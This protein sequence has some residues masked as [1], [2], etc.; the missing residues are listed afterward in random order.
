MTNT[1]FN[2]Y[3]WNKE[4]LINYVKDNLGDDAKVIYYQNNIVGINTIT[5][6]SIRK[7]TIGII[8]K[9]C[10]GTIPEIWDYYLSQD[11]CVSY[12]VFFNFNVNK[13]S[14]KSIIAL[15]CTKANECI[16]ID[17]CD[18]YHKFCTERISAKDNNF[19]S[20]KEISNKLGILSVDFSKAI[21][22]IQKSIFVNPNSIKDYGYCKALEEK[23]F[24]TY[25]NYI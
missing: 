4:S 21:Q 14:S 7:L 6:E 5:F 10:Y 25:K 8:K 11:D 17:G 13:N 23:I 9:L 24:K 19:F 15:L 2:S 16:Y 20:R 1:F 3:E 18:K 22:R 12:C